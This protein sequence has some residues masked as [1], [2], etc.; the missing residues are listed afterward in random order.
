MGRPRIPQPPPLAPPPGALLQA[1][2]VATLRDVAAIVR[3]Q[4]ALG[5]AAGLMRG[6]LL[7]LLNAGALP[8]PPPSAHLVELF[9]LEH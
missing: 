1:Q 9:C 6:S 7:H 4:A 2:L 5:E 8:A 3:A